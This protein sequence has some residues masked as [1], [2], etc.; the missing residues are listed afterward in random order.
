MSGY[1]CDGCGEGNLVDD[2]QG[3]GAHPVI[4]DLCAWTAD[5]AEMSRKILGGDGVPWTKRAR[6]QR[7]ELFFLWV[8]FDHDNMDA[9]F[10]VMKV[11]GLKSM[12]TSASSL[13]EVEKKPSDEQLWKLAEIPGVVEVR[14]AP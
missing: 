13:I 8:R 10:A 5:A 12:H 14:L 7:G 2:P 3:K 6:K 11:L 1:S 4:C 9:A